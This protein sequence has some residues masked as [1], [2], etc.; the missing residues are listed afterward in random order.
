MPCEKHRVKPACKN[1]KHWLPAVEVEFQTEGKD[2]IVQTDNYGWC[3]SPHAAANFNVIQ[4]KKDKGQTGL[5]TRGES[6]CKFFIHAPAPK[7]AE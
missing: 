4:G 1:C 7:P 5:Q 6:F 3:E 2:Y